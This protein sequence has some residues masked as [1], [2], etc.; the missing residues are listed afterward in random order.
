MKPEDVVAQLQSVSAQ[1]DR[2]VEVRV[3]AAGALAAVAVRRGRGRAARRT[4]GCA[5]PTAR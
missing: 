1:L 5:P 4:A 3:G 2:F